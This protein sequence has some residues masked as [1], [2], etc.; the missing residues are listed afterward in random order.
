VY[1]RSLTRNPYPAAFAKPI[2][3]DGSGFF[4]PL[5]SLMTAHLTR[6]NHLPLAAV[7]ACLVEQRPD[8]LP[9]IAKE[10]VASKTTPQALAACGTSMPELEAAWMAWGKKKFP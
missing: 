2:P 7:G 6:D 8:W 5:K 9:V 3:A 1:P 10:L 4:K